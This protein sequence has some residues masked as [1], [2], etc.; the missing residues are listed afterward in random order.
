MKPLKSTTALVMCMSLSMPAPLLAQGQGNTELCGDEPNPPCMTETGNMLL[1]GKGQAKDL[2]LCDGEDTLPCRT[3][4]GFLLVDGASD[5]AVEAM[6]ELTSTAVESGE[7]APGGEGVGDNS[8]TAQ[9]VEEAEAE[10]EA[11]EAESASEP[12]TVEAEASEGTT[13]EEDTTAETETPPAEGEATEMAQ[14]EETE[15]V[16]IT[17][18]P[19]AEAEAEAEVAAEVEAPVETQTEATAEAAP[20]ENPEIVEEVEEGIVEVEEAAVGAAATAETDT[21]DNVEVVEE[22][23][24]EETARSADEDFET[25]ASGNA[26]ASAS[27]SSDDGGLSNFEKALLVGLGAVAVGSILNNGDE[28]V[29]N[30]GDRVVVRGEDGAYR[31]LKDDDALLRQPGSQVRTETF[32]D[33]STR[34]TV[35][36]EDGTKIVTIRAADGRVVRRARVFEDGSQVVLFD[37]TEVAEPVDVSELPDVSERPQGRLLDTTDEDALRAALAAEMAVQTDRSYSLRQIRQIR[38][39]RELAP[40]IEL[41]AITFASGSAAIQPSQAEELAA[42]GRA[43]SRIIEENPGEVFLIEGHT[44]AVGAATYNLALSDRRAETVALALT[45]YFDVPPENMITQGYGEA[46]LKIRTLDD[47]RANRRAAVRRITPLL[48]QTVASNR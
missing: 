11:A 48:R 36:R 33:G 23:V 21:A 17:E 25:T 41:D 38:K 3:E 24:T 26:S 44:D 15:P 32:G 37:D 6:N 5:E 8:E 16:E 34:T 1:P 45:E 9:A 19:E 28:V 40:E 47:E 27:A 22:E 13:I 46:Y 42:L 10:T 2:E 18:A 31:V 39:V 43:M 20:V 4:E 30:S 7:P 12:E 29:T 35:T 14:T